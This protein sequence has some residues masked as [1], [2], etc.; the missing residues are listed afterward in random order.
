MFAAAVLFCFLFVLKSL[1]DS[2]ASAR[3]GGEVVANG[4]AFWEFQPTESSEIQY[5][6]WLCSLE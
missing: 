1:S 4:K 2:G 6:Y 5:Q 3:M